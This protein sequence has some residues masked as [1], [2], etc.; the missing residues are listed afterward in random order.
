MGGS[1]SE[2]AFSFYEMLSEADL[3]GIADGNLP[4]SD[5]VEK[6]MYIMI[7]AYSESDSTG[8]SGYAKSFSNDGVKVEYDGYSNPDSIISTALQ[9]VE[10]IFR[11]KGIYKSLAVKYRD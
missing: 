6:C 2:N 4:D 1:L 9:R 3:L 8:K 11:S 7:Q 5:T 10:K